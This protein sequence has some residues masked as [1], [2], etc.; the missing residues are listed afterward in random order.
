MADALLHYGTSTSPTPLQA[1][2]S[3][4]PAFN[5]INLTVTPPSGQQVY[6]DKIDVALP[7]SAPDGGGAYFT[8]AP[9]GVITGGDWKPPTAQLK[10]GREL[11]LA[12]AQNYFHVVFEPPMP[13]LDLV[14]GTLSFAISGNL[15]ITATGSALACSIT[16]TS[17]TTSGS[18]S[19]KDRLDLTLPTGEPVFY[20]NSL[21]AVAP[22]KPTIPRTKFNAGDEVALSWESNGSAFQLYDGDGTS[23][24]EGAATSCSIPADKVVNDTTYTLKATL[25]SGTPGAQPATLYATITLTIANPILR[26]V[27]VTEELVATDLT[28]PAKLTTSQTDGLRVSGSMTADS[29]LTVNGQLGTRDVNV[30][31]GLTVSGRLTA[32]GKA[33]LGA[34]FDEA[35]ELDPTLDGTDIPVDSDGIML[36]FAELPGRYIATFHIKEEGSSDTA[37]QVTLAG[38]DS[39]YTIPLRKGQSWCIT[40]IPPGNVIFAFHW[41]GFS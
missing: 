2:S 18:Y 5:T 24:Y 25:T 29:A 22:D 41:F 12:D 14:D 33:D 38:D 21:L 32:L 15:A 40:N 36:V 37:Y 17:G 39:T 23:L 1:G 27:T 19:R 10:S 11:G 13:D 20:L 31:G 30:G 3:D 6:C 8:E 26:H 9:D 16:E 4:K 35:V 28:V 7:A 34:L